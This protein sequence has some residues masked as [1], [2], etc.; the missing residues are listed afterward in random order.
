MNRNHIHFSTGLPEENS[1]VISGMRN[2]AEIL[3]YVDVKKSLEDGV[4]WWL[5]ENGVVLTE[6]DESGVLGTKHWTKVVG[7]RNGVG[8]MWEGGEIVE[9]LPAHLKNRRPPRGKEAGKEA[10]KI[11][12]GRNGGKAR[13]KNVKELQGKEGI[14][15]P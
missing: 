5:S 14:E 1:G 10:G 8:V 15:E 11:D 4:V 13:A 2:D 9:E 6:G 3:I 7:R 12:K